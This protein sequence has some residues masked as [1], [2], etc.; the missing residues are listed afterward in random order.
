METIQSPTPQPSA[1]PSLIV[2]L[3]TIVGLIILCFIPTLFILGLTQERMERAEAVQTEVGS[4]WGAEQTLSGPFLVIPTKN[5]ILPQ[6][7]TGDIAINNNTS[8]RVFTPDIFTYDID[9]QVDTRSRG[10]FDAT[11]YTS[12]VSGTGNITIPTDSN[13]LH[14]DQAQLVFFTTDP[15]DVVPGA[16]LTWNDERHDL[17][18]SSTFS[19]P[20]LT[21]A[22]P[23]SLD[24][25]SAQIAVQLDVKGN[26]AL[27][28]IP[29]G[30]RTETTVMSNWPDP[31]FVGNALPDTQNVRPDGFTATWSQSGIEANPK[32]SY[33]NGT[34]TDLSAAGYLSY[35]ITFFQEGTFYTKVE[36]T[37]KYSILFLGLTFL[38]FF[39]YEVLAGLRLHPIHYILVGLALG[40][41]YLLLLSIAEILGFL[42]AYALAAGATI[43]LITLYTSSILK[44][45]MRA[46]GLSAG[47]TAL[48]TYLYVLLQLE[49]Y[50]LLFG[51]LLLFGILA[52]VMIVTRKINWHELGR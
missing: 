25:Q 21:T 32:R 9:A 31:S 37:I 42:P 19:K 34:F 5:L 16:T 1:A 52:S 26:A 35:G 36:R 27:H 47:L 23:I 30:T 48:Y 14:Y 38:V 50:A 46:L 39:F 3:V 13:N 51:S 8:Y 10:I 45:F 6:A 44:S 49:N 41:F 22:F 33:T 29:T 7:V 40:V 20:A 15:R 17:T 43:G 24:N 11:V 28:I 12:S 18:Y 4:V 2:K